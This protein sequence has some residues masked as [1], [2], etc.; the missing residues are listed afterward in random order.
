MLRELS[1]VR[2]SPTRDTGSSINDHRRLPVHNQPGEHTCLTGKL[3]ALSSDLLLHPGRSHVPTRASVPSATRLVLAG[4]CVELPRDYSKPVFP[5]A[6]IWVG[7]FKMDW[8]A[9][10][11]GLTPRLLQRTLALT[12]GSRSVHEHGNSVSARHT[13]SSHSEQATVARI[14]VEEAPNFPEP[15]RIFVG[16]V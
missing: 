15:L 11:C 4:R 10:A 1:R 13:G 9:G 2:P 6:N 7:S 8:C 16:N 3:L 14:S 12:S 5:E